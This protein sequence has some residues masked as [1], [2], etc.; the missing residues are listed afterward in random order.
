MTDLILKGGTAEIVERDGKAAIKT[1]RERT[2]ER[3]SDEDRIETSY[4]TLADPQEAWRLGL[5]LIA[6]SRRLVDQQ[7][8]ARS[9]EQA[10]AQG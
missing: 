9:E 10:E 6:L 7:A 5:D 2:S 4:L 1:V 3:I 8:A